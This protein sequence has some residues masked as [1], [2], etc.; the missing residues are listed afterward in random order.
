MCVRLLLNRSNWRLARELALRDI[1]GTYSRSLL[2]FAWIAITPLGVLAIYWVVFSYVLGL[3]WVT[4][5][6]ASDMGYALPFFC[7]L[8]P[9]LAVAD[10]MSSATRQF[11]AK[12]T[13]VAKASFPL[14]V[15]PAATWVRSTIV[16]MPGLLFLLI[17]A[18]FQ[19]K[20]LT[21]LSFVSL[22]G[23]MCIAILSA[24]LA[25]LLSS[26]GAFF[27]DLQHALQLVIRAVFYTAPISYPLS[28]APGRIQ[29]W[30]L[31]N[32]LTSITEWIRIPLLYGTVPPI[33]ILLIASAY[34][35]GALAL[36]AFVFFRVQRFIPDVL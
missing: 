10:V 4:L 21:W 6:R 16:A 31:L 25:L 27:G 28:A 14:V 30:L 11:E 24:G 36:G 26:V 29:S 3:S 17:F 9:Y 7:G 2:G 20:N 34:S 13:L 22:G 33:E 35:A 19:G 1:Q 12:R 8:V 5:D 18:A 32:P 15:V 23:L